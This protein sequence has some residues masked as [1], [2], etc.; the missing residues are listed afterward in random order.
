MGVHQALAYLRKQLKKRRAKKAEVTAALLAAGKLVASHTVQVRSVSRCKVYATACNKP[1]AW[2]YLK[3]VSGTIKRDTSP[4]SLCHVLLWLARQS[5]CAKVDLD[6][7]SCF[8][9]LGGA[10]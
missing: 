7:M 3:D 6:Q 10:A 4:S 5:V 2:L 8:A 1:V 9:G